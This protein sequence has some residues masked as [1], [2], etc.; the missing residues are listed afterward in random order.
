MFYIIS[1]LVGE[2]VRT[3]ESTRTVYRKGTGDCFSTS[4]ISLKGLLLSWPS[5]PFRPTSDSNVSVA[6]NVKY[7]R[8]LKRPFW[9]QACQSFFP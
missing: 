7:G 2:G 3:N 5:I 9:S 4:L 8:V 1:E 6:M